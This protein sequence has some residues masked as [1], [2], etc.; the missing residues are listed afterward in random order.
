MLT[1]FFALALVSAA[2]LVSCSNVEK[3]R[4]RIQAEIS[5]IEDSL[6][7][8]RAL[9]NS[10]PS[11]PSINASDY[12]SREDFWA[13]VRKSSESSKNNPVRNRIVYFNSLQDSLQRELKKLPPE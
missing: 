3:E 4:E 10:R 7:I 5:V 11:S 13:A 1:R 12:S 8:Y 2:A 9:Y 6:K